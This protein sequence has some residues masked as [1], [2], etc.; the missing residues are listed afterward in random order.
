M[1]FQQKLLYI[2]LYVVST[3]F[4]KFFKKFLLLCQLLH[5]WLLFPILSWLF[6]WYVQSPLFQFL[7]FFPRE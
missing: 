5:K 4:F 6:H 7:L 1:S 3:L 2:T